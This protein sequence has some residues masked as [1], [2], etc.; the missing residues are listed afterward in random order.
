MAAFLVRALPD[1]QQLDPG[2]PFDDV[3]PT[4]T[5]FT[6]IGKLA[7]AGVTQGCDPSGTL[8]CPEDPVSR[9]QMAAF[10]YRALADTTGGTTTT[11]TTPTG[12]WR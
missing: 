6:E 1:L 4:H 11:T 3:P 10:L 12:Q 2:P 8:Y 7:T 5:F 9:G